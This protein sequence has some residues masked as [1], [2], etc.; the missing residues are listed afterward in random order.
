MG[1]VNHNQADGTF[2]NLPSALAYASNKA[3]N[4]PSPPIPRR[5]VI[6]QLYVTELVRLDWGRTAPPLAGGER[7]R[8][9]LNGFFPAI[10]AD[11]LQ[12]G[13]IRRAGGDTQE[14]SEVIGLEAQGE[15]SLPA[16]RPDPEPPR[17]H[18]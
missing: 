7:R 14:H 2:S 16:S 12:R 1:L 4:L 11:Y 17:T 3:M 6:S 5:Q 10:W 18:R 8:L 9:R 13:E 15:E